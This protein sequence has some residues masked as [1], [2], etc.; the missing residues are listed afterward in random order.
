MVGLRTDNGSPFDGRR[1]NSMR[2]VIFGLSK[3]FH[4]TQ[5]TWNT[6]NNKQ[7]PHAEEGVGFLMIFLFINLS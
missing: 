4:K 1:I 3:D 7:R 6:E 2:K 5:D